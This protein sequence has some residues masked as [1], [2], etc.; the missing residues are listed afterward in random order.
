MVTDWTT[1]PKSP[2]VE[3]N[4]HSVTE[5]GTSSQQEAVNS[6]G[7]DESINVHLSTRR[8]NKSSLAFVKRKN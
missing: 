7:P 1:E 2:E 5:E 4:D 6:A 3:R 8:I